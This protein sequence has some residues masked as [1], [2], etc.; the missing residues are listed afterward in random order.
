MNRDDEMV[1]HRFA[2]GEEPTV[3][4][5]DIRVKVGHEHCK[6]IDRQ[7]KAMKAKPCSAFVGAIDSSH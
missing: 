2:P 6:G 3:Y 5:A 1:R 4:T 7:S